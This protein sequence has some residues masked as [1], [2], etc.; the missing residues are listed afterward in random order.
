MK[1]EL[2]RHQISEFL[3]PFTGESIHTLL[4][5]I[6]KLYG[7]IFG[8]TIGHRGRHAFNTILNEMIRYIRTMI[9]PTTL[10]LNSWTNKTFAILL[11]E[12]EIPQQCSPSKI[13]C[14]QGN[15]EEDLLNE[16]NRH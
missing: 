6:V 8:N 1:S 10:P 12:P 5:F 16:I 14:G 13:E 4:F 3:G 15:Y 2:S 11:K 9:L 7:Q